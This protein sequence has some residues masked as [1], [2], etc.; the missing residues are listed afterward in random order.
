LEERYGLYESGKQAHPNNKQG[1]NMKKVIETVEGEGLEKYLGEKILLL[2]ANYFYTGILKGVNESCVLLE[3]AY[4]V[5]E[6]GEW[7]ASSYKDA[8]KLPGCIESFGA[9]K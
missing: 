9:G 7:S 2:C 8:Q 3:D 1:D 4:L 6:T 5:Y